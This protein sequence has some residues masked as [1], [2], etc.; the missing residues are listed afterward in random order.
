MES[1]R[2]NLE[3]NKKLWFRFWSSAVVDHAP[4]DPSQVSVRKIVPRWKKRFSLSGP[5]VPIRIKRN[6]NFNSRIGAL[7]AR[8]SNT[9]V[10]WKLIEGAREAIA[11]GMQSKR[12]A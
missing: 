11:E 8:H 1:I 2:Q 3:D 10:C 7:I 5:G 12:A 9:A 4:W 6:R